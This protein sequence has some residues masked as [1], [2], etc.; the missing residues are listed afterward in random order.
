MGYAETF[1]EDAIVNAKHKNFSIARGA[2]FNW[3]IEPPQCNAIGA[4]IVALGIENEF[5]NGFPNKWLDK[6]C[7]IINEPPFWL[8]RFI[9]GFD[10]GNRIMFTVFQDKKEYQE[11]DKISAQADALAKKFCG[12]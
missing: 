12:K 5:R 9:N 2:L 3:N 6:V 7:E 11:K 4:V 1:I 10:Y 8:W